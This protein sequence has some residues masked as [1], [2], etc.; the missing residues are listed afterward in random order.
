MKRVAR[1]NL[2]ADKIASEKLTKKIRCMIEDWRASQRLYIPGSDY[3]NVDLSSADE[4]THEELGLPSEYEESSE[5]NRNLCQMATI[6]VDLR[7][8]EA[9]EAIANTR[10]AVKKIGATVMDRD[11]NVKGYAGN[12][13]AKLQ[14]EDLQRRRDLHLSHYSAAR[15][16]L[17]RLRELLEDT[18]IPELPSLMVEDT[19]RKQPEWRRQIGD[20]RRQDGRIWGGGLAPST[21]LTYRRA[22]ENDGEANPAITS[23]TKRNTRGL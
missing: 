6:E 2:Q 14:L 16:S 17:M 15:T 23:S 21:G 22:R 4:I 12:T 1:R 11:K 13:R 18:S 9:R 8:A 5:W 7:K 10:S 3:C 19:A 20:S